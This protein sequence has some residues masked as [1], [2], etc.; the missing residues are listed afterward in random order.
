MNDNEAVVRADDH[1]AARG[2][3]VSTKPPKSKKAKK[4]AKSKNLDISIA[5]DIKS[6]DEAHRIIV[7]YH[8]LLAQKERSLRGGDEAGAEASE[9]KLKSLGGIRKY[10]EASI[11]DYNYRKKR[12]DGWIAAQL[13]Q[14][15]CSHLPRPIKLFDVG[16][17]CNFFSRYPWLSVTAIDIESRSPLVTKMD[18]FDYPLTPAAFDVVVLG[19]VVNFI[20]SP[21]KRGEMLQRSVYLLKNGG[22]L[23][24]TLPRACIDQSKYCTHDRFVSLLRD[25][26]LE[27]YP[28]AHAS[29]YSPKEDGKVVYYQFI[30]RAGCGHCLEDGTY[31]GPAHREGLVRKTGNDFSTVL[32]PVK[33][34]KR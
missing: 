3:N 24:I 1:E 4:K 9:A 22:I 10:Q 5:P 33:A 8:V 20:P 6:R 13:Q 23:F 25:L 28:E 21:E 34:K 32:L 11:F 16:S 15:H 14:P 18:F 12:P 2:G 19:L 29:A 27:E 26:G 7:E 17:L 31:V 30:K